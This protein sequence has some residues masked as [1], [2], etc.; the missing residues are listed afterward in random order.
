VQFAIAEQ[1]SHLDAGTWN[2]LTADAGVFMQ[3]PFLTALER[4]C[5]ANVSPRYALMSR[6]GEPLA[7]LVLQLVRVQ[8]RLAIS[9]DTPLGGVAQLFDERALVLGNLAGWGQTGLAMASG[10]DV[11]LVWREALGVLDRV[12]RFEKP[13]GIINVSFVKDA[14]LDEHAPSLRH[15]GF[16]RAPSGPDMVLDLTA[17]ASFDDYLG[18]LASKRRRS[19]KKT[20]EAVEQAGY[21]TRPLTLDELRTHEARLDA[22]Y[23]EVWSNADVRPLRLT[24]RFFVELKAALGEAC[25]VTGLLR[26]DQLDGFGVCLKSGV[27]GVGYY[28]GFD[29]SVEAPLYQR[30]LTSIVEQGCAWQ[31]ARMSMG[32]TTEEPKVLLGATP[33]NPGLWVKHR[34]PPFNWAV[35]TFLG[36]LEQPKVPEHRVFKDAR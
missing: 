15:H 4:A 7:A 3:R 27:D 21:V 1:L 20:L 17:F 30:L 29:R 14:L 13:E 28:L 36:T 25:V 6:D 8:G 22:L 34:T 24:G 16:Q 12:R 26:G 19:V 33:G 10:V 31:C 11:E 23:G 18:S 32:R 35:S 5:P 9:Q 2:A